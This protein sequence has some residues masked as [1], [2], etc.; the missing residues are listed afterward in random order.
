MNMPD[1]STQL[2]RELEKLRSGKSFLKL[3]LRQTAAS[4]WNQGSKKCSAPAAWRDP[5]SNLHYLFRLERLSSEENRQLQAYDLQAR[6]SWK[7][8]P[9]FPW[10]TFAK[11]LDL[12]HSLPLIL[13][14]LF[15]FRGS[16]NQIQDDFEPKLLEKHSWG[17]DASWLAFVELGKHC[18]WSR[19]RICQRLRDAKP[20]SGIAAPIR[21]LAGYFDRWTSKSESVTSY[22]LDENDVPPARLNRQCVVLETLVAKALQ[23]DA[24]N[25]ANIASSFSRHPRA[26]I[27]AAALYEHV[28]PK[29]VNDWLLRYSEE[30]LGVSYRDILL[31]V[32]LQWQ[33]DTALQT[34]VRV[35]EQLRPGLSR[36]F[37]DCR[38]NNLLWITGPAG[39]A[40]PVFQRRQAQFFFASE[41]WSEEKSNLRMLQFLI[42]EMGVSPFQT[43]QQGFCFA[44]FDWVATAAG[45]R[46]DI[47]GLDCRIPSFKEQTFWHYALHPQL[48]Q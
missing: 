32:C 10:E 9:D 28:C 19:K 33:D 47:I 35:L 25:S 41:V 4:S 12:E 21:L 43:N 26:V 23:Q 1:S 6:D 30:E 5:G 46:R 42:A 37:R 7:S 8:N 15:E 2:N 39:Y 44:D 3:L 27:F 17:D 34:V 38:G 29:L 31:S 36:D 22:H 40:Q 11:S 48:R 16:K 18:H 45:K 20:D 24:I 14:A 13:W